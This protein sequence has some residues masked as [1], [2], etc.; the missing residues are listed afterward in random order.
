MLPTGKDEGYGWVVVGAVFIINVIVAG[1]IKSFG[2]LLL[3]IQEYFP[4]ASNLAMGLVM[5]LLNGC[6]GLTAPMMGA[7]TV[8]IGARTCVVIGAILTSSGLLLAVFSTNMIHIAFTIGAIA[9]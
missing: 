1:Y 2:L 3:A 9:G 8:L 6:R 4:D 5:S 7:I